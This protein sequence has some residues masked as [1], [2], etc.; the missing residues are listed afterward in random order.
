MVF[1]HSEMAALNELRNMGYAELDNG[2]ARPGPRAP[3]SWM[4][5]EAG[6]KALRRTTRKV[7]A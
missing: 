4:I 1:R 3:S 7:T 5:T 6:R 2:Q